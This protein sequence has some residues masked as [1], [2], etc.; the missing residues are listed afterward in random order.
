MQ[1]RNLLAA[2]AELRAASWRQHERCGQLD[3]WPPR[4]VQKLHVLLWCRRKRERA[5]T[6]Q[7]AS[8]RREVV[9]L[10]R[11]VIAQT[12]AD[13][14]LA[15]IRCR[16]HPVA[17]SRRNAGLINAAVARAVQ[18]ARQTLRTHEKSTS[19]QRLIVEM[20]TFVRARAVVDARCV[21]RV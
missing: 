7:I 21:E 5:R 9:M 13:R 6:P 20:H 17:A 3:I 11:P 19:A 14:L 2:V 12:T 10:A 16:E 18:H 15:G 4:V 1:Q 8:R